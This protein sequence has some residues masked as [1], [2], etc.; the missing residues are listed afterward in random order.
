MT[1]PLICSISLSTHQKNREIRVEWQNTQKTYSPTLLRLNKGLEETSFYLNFFLDAAKPIFF[2]E[3]GRG[4]VMVEI[5]DAI[6]AIGYLTSAAQSL[7]NTLKQTNELL[8]RWNSKQ[9]F[10]KDFHRT[11]FYSADDHPDLK[12]LFEEAEKITSGSHRYLS[13]S[14]GWDKQ[15]RE[16]DASSS[17]K[18]EDLV[19]FIEREKIRRIV[20]LNMY[21]LKHR[22]REGVFALA[23]L[24]HLG[25]EF[26]MVDLDVYDLHWNFS[27]AVFNDPQ[28]PRFSMFPQI[29]KEWDEAYGLTNIHYIPCSFQIP[30]Q[31]KITTTR[32]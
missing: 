6:E 31:K 11:L 7:Q 9:N 17:L 19:E 24:R 27:K 8:I 15:S 30:V 22:L 18:I 3:L 20:T 10:A 1:K 25:V 26:V 21:Y 28:N 13:F 16:W 4:E 2:D 29:A 23:I 14:T 32:E 12:T 5:D